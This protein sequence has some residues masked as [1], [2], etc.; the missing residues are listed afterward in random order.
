MS[1][2]PDLA[3]M[4][5]PCPAAYVPNVEALTLRELCVCYVHRCASTKV[6][7]Y[8]SLMFFWA[9]RTPR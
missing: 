6:L 8:S 9:D 3:P 4:T 2:H 1:L 5:Y 7:R